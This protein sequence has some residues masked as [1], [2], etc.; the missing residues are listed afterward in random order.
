MKI[1]NDSTN[2]KDVCCICLEDCPTSSQYR[3][4]TSCKL[5]CHHTCW[6]DYISEN[7][8]IFMRIH[9]TEDLVLANTKLEC[10][11]CRS[12]VPIIPRVTRSCTK[13]MRTVIAAMKIS[14]LLD[15][16]AVQE[17]LENKHMCYSKLVKLVSNNICIL[18][19]ETMSRSIKG[20]L[21]YLHNNNHWNLANHYH[22]KFFGHAVNK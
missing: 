11:M 7:I 9:D 15:Y 1:F 12:M 6:H 13:A 17:A 21:K 5:S 18:E 8:K 10:P 2:E 14:A 19:D 16:I 3:R 20:Y 22:V 4:C